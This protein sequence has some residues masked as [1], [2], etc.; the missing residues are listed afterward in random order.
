MG[1]GC[2]DPHFLE[3]GTSWRW[4]VSSRPRPFYPRGKSICYPLYMRFGEPQSRSGRRG[5][6]K[7]LTLSGL[8]L[9]PLGHPARS[10]S[11]YRRR[12]PDVRLYLMSRIWVSVSRWSTR[13]R[14]SSI[15]LM[16]EILWKTL[17]YTICTYKCL[18]YM[19]NLL[20]LH[21]LTRHHML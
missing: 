20:G 9:R 7:L 18:N 12:Y 16:H 11:L 14:R 15:S 10:Q 6:E 21:T 3:I 4:V 2:I 17:L 13:L 1:S 5:E 19:L 8:E